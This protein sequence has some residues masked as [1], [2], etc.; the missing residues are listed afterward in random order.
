VQVRA[1]QLPDRPPS[2]S[3]IGAAG[4]GTTHYRVTMA[5]AGM[6]VQTGAVDPPEVVIR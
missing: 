2:C 5:T 4:L 1:T 6:L 3:N